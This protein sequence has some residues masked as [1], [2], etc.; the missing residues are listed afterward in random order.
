MSLC[1]LY[2]IWWGGTSGRGG[3]KVET[4]QV[5]VFPAEA[6]ACPLPANNRSQFNLKLEDF[7]TCRHQWTGHFS[8]GM[9]IR[10]AT[11]A[12]EDWLR[13]RI[14]L[15]EPDLRRKH[16]W[17]AESPFAFL[18]ATF[19]RWVQLWPKV[20][21]ELS[22]APTV[23]GVGDLHVENFGTW[24]DTEGRL[25]WGVNDFDEVWQIPYTNDLVRLAV[26]ARLAISENDLSYDPGDACDAILAGYRDGLASGGAPFVLAE[27]HRGLRAWA[28]SELRDP[29]ASAP[30]T[31]VSFHRACL[32]RFNS[33]IWELRVQ[34]S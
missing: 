1:S 6:W 11:E 21:L 16:Q 33:L 22:S 32:P 29:V 7:W 3:L 12:Y 8:V 18:R 20:C 17:M 23:L 19:Y 27:Q 24:R 13:A 26:S 9:N 4:F 14:P 30:Q 34:K 5:P 10:R 2:N 31:L 28:L 15:L 25:I